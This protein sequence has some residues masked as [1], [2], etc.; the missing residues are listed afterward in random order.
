MSARV[1]DDYEFQQEICRWLEA[2]GI[3]YKLV[4]VEATVYEDKLTIDMFER[5]PGGGIRSDGSGRPL[6]RAH[7][8]DITTPPPGRVADWVQPACPTCGR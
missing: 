1:V 8:F 3:D 5:G 7:T 6:R 2:N 4:P